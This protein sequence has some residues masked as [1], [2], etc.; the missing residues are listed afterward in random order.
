MGEVW[1][2]TDT[3][4]NDRLVALKL[5]PTELTANAD[6]AARF[7]RVAEAVARLSNP[8]VVPIHDYGEIEDRLFIDMRMVDGVDLAALV[9]RAAPV[10]PRRAVAI[11]EQVADALDDA[12]AAGLVHRDVKPS[13]I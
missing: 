8:H 13:N 3:R 5:L 12:H 2:A 9:G 6:F 1:R 7:R 11:V 10:D 4:K